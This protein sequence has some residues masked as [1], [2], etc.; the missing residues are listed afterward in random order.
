MKTLFE[1]MMTEIVVVIILFVFAAFSFVDI[2]ALAAR[3]IHASVVDQLQASY[4]SIELDDLND[5]LHETHPTWTLTIEEIKTYN[6]RKE[7]RVSLIYDVVVPLFNIRKAGLIEG[8]T[9]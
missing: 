2:Q 4:Y 5:K 8:Y 9:R 7:Y 6:A 1:H 3:R